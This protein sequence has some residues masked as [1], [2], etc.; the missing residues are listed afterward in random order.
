MYR[1]IMYL[2]VLHRE[3]GRGGG[4]EKEEQQQQ[5]EY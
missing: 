2:Y 1:T 4:G 5:K 3:V